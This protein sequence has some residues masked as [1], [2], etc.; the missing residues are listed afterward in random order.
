MKSYTEKLHD[1]L[2]SKLEELNR[3]YD[4]QQITDPRLHLITTAIDQIKEK[5]RDHH[6]EHEEEE[7]HYFKKI[8]PETMALY[9]YYSDKIEWDR[10]N[11][12]GSPEFS[13]KFIDRIYL[14]AE[15][16]RKDYKNI[17]EYS[18]DEKS[19]LDK[20]YFLRKS[21]INSECKYQLGQII[22]PSSPPI[23][24]EL[25][26]MNIA[27]SRLEHEMK[28]SLKENMDK[29]PPDM[30]NEGHLS[31]T[32]SKASATELVYGL[33]H[34]GLIDNG[35][36]SLKK[37]ATWFEKTFSVDLGNTS[38]VFQEIQARKMGHISV[39]DKL[40]EAFKKAIDEIDEEYFRKNRPPS[41]SPGFK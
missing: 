40:K 3:N 31:W 17:Y 37:I 23:H 21:P 9:I 26:A 16:F 30:P 27:Y 29:T 6:F 39:F 5:L 20:I 4:P 34:S 24:C 35:N 1:E 14:Q 11:R 18:R 38:K 32:G 25:L 2:L 22:D 13:Y 28:M 41:G 19:H 8:L 15:N 36:A 10:I 33:K 7:I 12:Q